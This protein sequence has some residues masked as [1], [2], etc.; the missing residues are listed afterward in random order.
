MRDVARQAGVSLQSVSNV[1]NGRNSQMSEETRK[2]ILASIQELGYQPDSQARGLRSQRTNTVAFLTIDP[3]TRF[4][5]DPFHVAILSGMVDVLRERDYAMF[6]QGLEPD[7]AGLAFQRLAH[8]R[9]FDGA[10]VH[11][12]GPKESRAQHIEQ[13]ERSGCPFVLVQERPSA[14]TASCV[15]ADDHGGAATAVS[16]LL[17][18]GHQR[19]GFLATARSWPAVDARKAG[20]EQALRA[21]GNRKPDVWNVEH[22][23]IEGA[24]T[25]MEDVLARVP[26]ITAFLCANDVLAVG[27]L[28]AAK[29]LGRVVPSN[30][31]IVGF[32]DFEFARYVDP[33]LTTVSLPAYEMGRRSADMLLEFFED[34][35]FSTQEVL[36]PATLV[37]RGTA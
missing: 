6:V 28:Q 27:A 20:Y 8:Q 5:A 2:R 35:K 3:A 24:R 22:E 34:G 31:A 32:N 16:L 23:S 14:S 25:V 13:L 15:L 30:V 4:L 1:L 10:V 21:V 11:L 18:R 29:Q 7:S 17:A 26:S 37:E 12:S 33:P 9:R 19:I 36:F